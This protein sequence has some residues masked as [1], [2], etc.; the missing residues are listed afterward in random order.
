MCLRNRI[1]K[2][3]KVVSELRVYAELSPGTDFDPKQLGSLKRRCDKRIQHTHAHSYIH[4]R[5]NASQ[6]TTKGGY[7]SEFQQLTNQ[8]VKGV[9]ASS[10]TSRQTDFHHSVWS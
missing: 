6:H 1:Q 5:M 2:Y 9:P 7:S 4:R 3:V 10:K 8:F